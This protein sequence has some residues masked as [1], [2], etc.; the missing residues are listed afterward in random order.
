MRILYLGNLDSLLIS[1]LQDQDE[2]VIV[3]TDN[4]NDWDYLENYD[5]LISYNYRYILKKKV[6][7]KFMGRAINLHISL[8]PWNRGAD[9]NLWSWIDDTP[10]G[11]TIHQLD[12]GVDTG[13]I[14]IQRRTAFDHKKQLTLRNTYEI[15]QSDIQDLFKEHWHQLRDGRIK[16]VPQQGKGSYHRMAG[17]EKIIHLLTDGWDTPVINLR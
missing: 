4:V 3:T 9:P 17:K 6:L 7:D 11:V 2:I 1:W 12:K 10:K 14:L 15:L 8:L 5:F 13:G 16:P